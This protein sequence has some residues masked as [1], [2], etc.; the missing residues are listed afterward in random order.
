MPSTRRDQR[1]SRRR[2]PVE[3]DVPSELPAAPPEADPPIEDPVDEASVE[4]PGPA[5]VPESVME[6]MAG[7]LSDVATTI[8]DSWPADHTPKKV[9]MLHLED[10]EEVLADE[11]I[12]EP[13]SR[14]RDRRDRSRRARSRPDVVEVPIE[15]PE[16]E[17]ESEEEPK[18][19]PTEEEISDVEEIEAEAPDDENTGAEIIAA[20]VA[21]HGIPDVEIS[22]EA[23]EKLVRT[24][25][26]ARI[27]NE[28]IKVAVLDTGQDPPQIEDLI[29]VVEGPT[30][31][32]AEAIQTIVD[33][34]FET[35][36]VE[37]DTYVL[38]VPKGTVIYLEK[39]E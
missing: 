8:K 19:V 39:K 18:E 29:T 23:M 30:E 22:S 37:I 4:I 2:Q 21:E 5:E 35:E 32:V 14:A 34:D 31:H 26:A 7:N 3:K 12:S 33:T 15:E 11:E 38:R 16:P 6:A 10:A 17:E 25:Q 24:G 20:A 28:P 36:V 13:A 27:P 1:R 9:G